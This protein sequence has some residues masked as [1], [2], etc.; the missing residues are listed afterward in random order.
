MVGLHDPH[1]PVGCIHY[2]QGV[3]V[4]LVEEFCNFI[5]VGFGLTG[6]NARLGKN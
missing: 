5:L 1:K 6:N 2:R 4:V 3:Q